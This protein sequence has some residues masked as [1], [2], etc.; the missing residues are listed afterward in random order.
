MSA[1]YETTVVLPTNGKMYG[2]EGPREVTLRAM[3]TKEEKI[4]LGS[5]GDNTFDKIVKSCIVSPSDL[6]LDD[7]IV[8]DSHFLLMKLRAHT[9]GSDYHIECTCPECG[10][11]EKKTINLDDFPVYMLDD[12]FKEP[13]EFTLP[14]SG[15]KLECK[16]LRNKDITYVNRLAHKLARNTKTSEE[17]I[18]YNI[19][20][21][22]H[23]V[24]ING[25][26]VDDAT[27]Q[28]YTQNMH[29]R[30]SAYFWWS[31]NKVLVGYDT[32]VECT[33]PNCGADYEIGMPIT[34]EFFRPSFD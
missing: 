9:Y 5:T 27:A 12:D 16:L 4:L 22:R 30:D 17:E 8:S 7:L 13:I 25:E 19:R 10:K 26:D 34:S 20:M 1:K 18:A 2:A 3:T 23:I 6:N 31:L 32:T 29:G 15:D 24:R 21:S 33:C 28:L 14:M 11:V